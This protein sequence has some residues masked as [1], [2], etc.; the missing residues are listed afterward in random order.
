MGGG[1]F[2]LW[3]SLGD[4]RHQGKVLLLHCSQLGQL[5]FLLSVKRPHLRLEVG[6]NL[7]CKTSGHFSLLMRNPSR[8]PG[9]TGRIQKG[10]NCPP[11]Q[12]RSDTGIGRQELREGFVLGS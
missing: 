2:I 8:K 10:I 6:M 12:M 1:R 5:L 4:G 7:F 9:M 11:T 3:R